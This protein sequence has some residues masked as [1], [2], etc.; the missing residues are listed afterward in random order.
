M[1]FDPASRFLERSRYYLGLEYPA[2]LRSA[3]LALPSDRLWWRANSASNSAGNLLLHLAGN[4]RQWIVSGIGGAPDARDRDAEFT[5][6]GGMSAADLLD[7]LEKVLSEVDAVLASLTPD[8]L[9]TI[10]RIQGR[11]TTVFSA[12]Y[13][14]VEH[15]SGHVGQII[16]LAKIHAPG[17]VRFYEDQGGLARP[18]F[19]GDGRSDVE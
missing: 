3:V 6:T 14:V 12:L 5:A 17:E 7:H 16:L 4:A 19:L 13:H 1:T 18:V 8:D 9:G 15:F 10:R 2:K 11:D